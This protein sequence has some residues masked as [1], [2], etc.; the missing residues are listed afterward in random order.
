MYQCANGIGC[1]C[2][3]AAARC[4]RIAQSVFRIYL[5]KVGAVRA[6]LAKQRIAVL[7]HAL[8]DNHDA[9]A[10]DHRPGGRN[11]R[12]NR[13]EEFDGRGAEGGDLVGRPEMRGQPLGK[14]ARRRDPIHFFQRGR[15]ASIARTPPSTCLSCSGEQRAQIGKLCVHLLRARPEIS[16]RRQSPRAAATARSPAAAGA[17]RPGRRWRLA[18][19]AAD[20]WRSAQAVSCD[21]RMTQIRRARRWVCLARSAAKIRNRRPASAPDPAN[22]WAGRSTHS[23]ECRD[24]PPASRLCASAHLRCDD[25]EIRCLPPPHP[26][27]VRSPE[28]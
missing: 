22:Q 5:G 25:A 14:F 9:Q 24:P 12:A 13:I 28:G 2:A 1:S 10:G 11:R 19:P 4:I 6:K 23:R 8:P 15:K 16:S 26:N 17:A 20:R 18:A 3:R 7:R 21:G 27:P